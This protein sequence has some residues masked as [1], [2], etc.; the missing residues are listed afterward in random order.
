MKKWIVPAICA[1]CV[2]FL[3]VTSFSAHK[4]KAYTSIGSSYNSFWFIPA[5]SVHFNVTFKSLFSGN[6]TLIDEKGNPLSGDK[7]TIFVDGKKTGPSFNVTNV[8][9]VHVAIRCTKAVSPGKQYIRVQGGGPLVTHVYFKHHLNPLVVW[10]SWILTIFSIVTLIWFSILRRVFYPQFRSVQKVFYVPNQ[11]PLI[12]KMTGARM[13]VIS[14]DKRSQ[15]FWDSLIKGPVFYKVHPSFTTPIT[16]TPVRGGKVL[17]KGDS[18]I[19]HV[20]PNPMPAIGSAAI[21]NLRSKIHI[22]IN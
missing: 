19:Y 8:K 1:V 12:L 4:G 13:V 21:D 17:V 9:S 18:S 5:K 15:S 11:Q 22:T 14:A 7:Y 6:L 16:L 10:L 2:V 3:I 20:L